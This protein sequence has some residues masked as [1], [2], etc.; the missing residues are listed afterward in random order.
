MMKTTSLLAACF[1]F[2]TNAFAQN[3]PE[4][5]F[6]WTLHDG[7]SMQ[8]SMKVSEKG[9][10]ISK[11]NFTTTEWYNVNVPTTIIAGLLANHVYDFD[12]ILCQKTLKKSQD[13]NLINPGGSEKN[14]P[15]CF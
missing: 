2:I 9:D 10:A 4:K 11:T 15:T 7:W 14:L 13:P 1:L 3:F 6:Q 8:S 5:K 12:P